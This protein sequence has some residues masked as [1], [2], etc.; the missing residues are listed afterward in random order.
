MQLFPAGRCDHAFRAGKDRGLSNE[1]KQIL[2]SQ[3]L[4][5]PYCSLVRVSGLPCPTKQPRLTDP[6]DVKKLSPRTRLK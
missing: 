6:V 3:S 2:L 5:N 4:P 1:D